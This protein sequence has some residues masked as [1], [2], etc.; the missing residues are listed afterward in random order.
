[1]FEGVFCFEN[2]VFFSHA[3]NRFKIDYHLGFKIAVTPSP[4]KKG[5]NQISNVY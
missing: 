4:S 3:E 1:M 2:R 5:C